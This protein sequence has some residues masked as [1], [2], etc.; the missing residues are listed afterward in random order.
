MTDN[1]IM[2]VCKPCWENAPEGCGHFD[3]GELA[4]LSDGTW[5][6]Q[7]CHDHA[8]DLELGVLPPW[9]ELPA[10]ALYIPKTT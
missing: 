9:S 2:Y 3:R 7:E 6:C 8:A 4:E 5:I 1:K 10:P